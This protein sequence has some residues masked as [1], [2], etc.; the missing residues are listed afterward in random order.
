[1]SLMAFSMGVYFSESPSRGGWKIKD[2][3]EESY[4][5]GKQRINFG[6]IFTYNIQFFAN[7][8]QKYVIFSYFFVHY[9]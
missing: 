2:L 4:G 3:N 7:F 9:L 8:P 1:M 6:H 5:F